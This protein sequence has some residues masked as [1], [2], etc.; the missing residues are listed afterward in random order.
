VTSSAP[1]LLEATDCHFRFLRNPVDADAG[2]AGD[3]ADLLPDPFGRPIPSRRGYT[4]ASTDN[5]V[6]HDLVGGACIA[7]SGTLFWERGVARTGVA[8]LGA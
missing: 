2:F 4:C 5:G 8:A 6:A 3:L 7:R 1:Q